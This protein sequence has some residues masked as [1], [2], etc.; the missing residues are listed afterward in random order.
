MLNG[1]IYV[2]VLWLRWGYDVYLHNFSYIV[3]VGF[4]G[5]RDRVSRGNYRPAESH[6]S[7]LLHNVVSSTPRHESE[8]L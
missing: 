5:G 8:V 6:G 3:L 7:T 4:I 2:R 1:L